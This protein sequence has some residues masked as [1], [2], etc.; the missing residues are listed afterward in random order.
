MMRQKG[1]MLGKY[2]EEELLFFI[3]VFF[4]LLFFH[5]IPFL[6]GLLFGF[7]VLFFF[8]QIVGDEI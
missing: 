3:V 1:G 6:S 2:S 4:L 5:K 8:I 7:F